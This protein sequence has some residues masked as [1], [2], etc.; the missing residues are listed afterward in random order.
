MRNSSLVKWCCA[1]N[2]TG[3]KHVTEAAGSQK[4]EDRGEKG[5]LKN[6]FLPS[7][8]SGLWAVGERCVG[9]TSQT[10][11]TGAAYTSENVGMSS[12]NYV[13]TIVAVSLRFP[14]EG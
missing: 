10:E 7:A 12:E 8:F 13:R 11:R 1:E 6:S 2:V 14:T 9:E 4:G 3:L 5:E